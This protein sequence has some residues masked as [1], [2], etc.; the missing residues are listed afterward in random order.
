MKRCGGVLM[1]ISSLPGKYGIGTLGENAK[2]FADF[3]HN[4]KFKVWQVLPCGPCDEYNSPYSGKSAFAGNIYFIDPEMLY[5]EFLLTE[6]DL[7]KCECDDIYVTGYEFL[8][9][10]REEIFRKA[11]DRF[12]NREKVLDFAKENPWV[13]DYALFC[14]LKKE[15]S[16]PWYEWEDGI[17][18]RTAE[19][20]ENAKERLSEDILFY[21][22]LQWEFFSQ[23]KE[24]KDYANSKGIQLIGDMPIYLSHD[25]A[26]VWANPHLFS[27]D[28]DMHIER[29]AGV[30]PD[31]FC[32]EGQKWGNPLYNWENLKKENY[33]LWI[34][35]LGNA[36]K[37][38]DAVRIDH[39]R[40]FSAYWSI[41]AEEKATEGRWEKGPGIEFFNRL[42]EIYPDANIIAED[43][44]DIDDDVRTLLKE[45]GFPGMGVM[46]FAFITDDDTPHLPHNYTNK[47]IG[48]TGTHDN[49]TLLGWL[50]EAGEQSRT[51]ALDYCN[52][53]GDWGQGG[54][55]SPAIQ[56][57]IR[58]LWS[59]G[60]LISI[61]PIQDLCGFGGDTCMNHPGVAE[62][63][64]CFR[65]TEDA[66]GSI[67]REFFRNI[68][69][70]Y[71]R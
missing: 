5:N 23:W 20:L 69:A 11:F 17:K 67:D 22:F 71:K 66:L 49:N 21:E 68:N 56:S 64:W 41:P 50:W 30:P 15:N 43:L 2:K 14:A 9:K 16:A 38:Y 24:L 19:A 54:P 37:M 45:T 35:R 39:F 36:L 4:C 13:E 52:F 60:A 28:K 34:E 42:K 32:E 55:H 63:N 3:L 61:V 7:N 62:G 1:H 40:A 58:T 33:S 6:E 18:K 26:D 53:H 51:Y 70:L 65:I 59:S 44:G 25:S 47:T 27:L 12:Q 48:Y 31:Y 57:I 29:C 8:Y 10:T 46:Q